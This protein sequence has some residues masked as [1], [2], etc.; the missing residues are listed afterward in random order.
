LTTSKYGALNF[1]T[2]RARM[3]DLRDGAGAAETAYRSV[4]PSVPGYAHYCPNT[5]APSA[6]RHVDRAGPTRRTLFMSDR[7][8][9]VQQNP[10]L[11]VLLE[12]VWVR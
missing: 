5:V 3:V 1:A 9:N 2:D 4:P 12:R 11:G 6:A 8:G 10:M 7:A